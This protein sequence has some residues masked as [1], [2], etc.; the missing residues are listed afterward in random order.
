M[1][2]FN[3]TFNGN[4][5]T[6]EYYKDPTEMRGFEFGAG[7]KLIGIDIETRPTYSHPQAGLCPHM[8]AIR[9]IQLFDGERLVVFDCLDDRMMEEIYSHLL[10]SGVTK[11]PLIAHYAIFDFKH[12]TKAGWNIHDIHCSML[13]SSFVDNAEHSP[14]ESDE[15]GTEDKK[16][17]G[18]SLAACSQRYLGV[19]LPKEEQKSDWA[20]PTL[21]TKQIVYAATDVIV[22][23]QLGKTLLKKMK[24]HKIVKAYQFYRK[25]IP[26]IAEMELNGFKIDVERHNELIKEWEKKTEIAQA[27]CDKY[28]KGVNMRS[29]KQLDAWVKNYYAKNKRIINAWPKSEKTGLCSFNKT[30]LADMPEPP[31]IKALLAYKKHAVLL[32]TFGKALQDKIGPT[33][34]IHCSYSLGETRTGRLSSRNPNLQNM[35]S[36]DKTFKEIFVAERGNVLVVA[37]FSQIEIRVAGQLAKDESILDQYRRGVDLHKS[38]VSVL[39]GKPLEDVTDEERF[40]GKAI[41]FGLQFGMGAKKLRKYAK[42]SYGVELSEKEAEAAYKAYHSKYKVYSKWCDSQRNKCQRLGFVRTPLGRKRKLLD[43][44]V[45]TKSVNTPV[46]G[47]AA[48]VCFAALMFLHE[49]IIHQG[50]RDQIKIIN[51]VHDEILLEVKNYAV[52]PAIELLEGCM[53][54]GMEDI[55]PNAVTKNLVEAH[56][57]HSWAEAK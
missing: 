25:M 38:I 31:P 42:D 15:E 26:V 3:F 57:G 27:E 22:T 37:D 11:A 55:F 45:Y 46:Q 16:K 52:I 49:E 19:G 1:K 20:A 39:S 5:Y 24:E 8:S 17:W 28:F 53:A 30:L 29:P 2:K 56:A 12:L 14:F 13:M 21:T 51:T 32:S 50:Y 41:N 40:L 48:E 23:Y 47:G 34:R 36:R 9:L 35:P 18:L 10:A 44:E 43:N 33:G 4:P 7:A 54:A 6:A